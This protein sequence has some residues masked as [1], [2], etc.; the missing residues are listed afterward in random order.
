MTSYQI[1]LLTLLT[2]SK[3]K[4]MNNHTSNGKEGVAMIF[5]MVHDVLCMF[6][7]EDVFSYLKKGDIT[8]ELLFP[9]PSGIDLIQ[10]LK[11]MVPNFG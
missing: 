4:K 5:T 7:F 2:P 11:I 6:P 9:N 8:C 10:Q 1:F 3:M